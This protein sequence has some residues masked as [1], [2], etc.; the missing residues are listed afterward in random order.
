MAA[1]Q[2]AERA[3]AAAVLPDA[4]PLAWTMAVQAME[5]SLAAFTRAS[6]TRQH[7]WPEAIRNAA[8]AEARLQALRSLRDAA[9]APAA[10]AES[11][12][13]PQPLPLPEPA[14]EPVPE[15]VPPAL[16][17]DQLTATELAKVLQ[18]VQQKEREKRGLRRAVQR[19]AGEAGERAW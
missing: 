10:R 18:R 12:P 9:A 11:P 6:A 13:P 7:E 8:R 17:T 19:R 2:R 15:E 5:R 1:C 4:E 16:A 14:P 3:A